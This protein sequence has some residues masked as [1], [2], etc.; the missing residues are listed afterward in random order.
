MNFVSID[1]HI[2]LLTEIAELK[3]QAK[4]TTFSDP[5]L[6]NEEPQGRPETKFDTD[7]KRPEVS[8]LLFSASRWLSFNC[9]TQMCHAS[10]FPYDC[11]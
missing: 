8:L 7:F 10:L 3:S 5:T 9:P 6:P 2:R 1:C 4:P 11:M